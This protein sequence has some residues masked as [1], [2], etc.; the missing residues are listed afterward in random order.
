MRGVIR[1]AL[2]MTVVLCA[3]GMLAQENLAGSTQTMAV[4]EAT[5]VAT[6][7]AA[8][9]WVPASSVV[10]A[11]DAGLRAHTNI[12]LFSLD[13]NKPAG[14][15]YP[16][17]FTT[18]T[19]DAMMEAETPASLGCLYV[20]SPSYS[21]CAPDPDPLTGGPSA[22]GYGAIAIVDAFDNPNAATDLTQFDNYWGL[23][24]PANFHKIL[25]T[26]ASI[27]CG[28]PAANANWSLESSLDI[29]WAHVFAPK[30]QIVLVE[31]SDNSYTCL[32]Y[33]EQV[34]FTYVAAHYSGGHVSNSWG[35]SEFSGQ[36]SYDPMFAGYTYSYTKQI[37]GFASTGDN[38][39]GV[40]YPSTNPW[41]V[42]VGGTSVVRDSATSAF[43]AEAC[44]GGAGGGTSSV[45]TYATTWNNGAQ[46][47]PWANYQ[48]PIFGKAARAV[49]D[50]S[51]DA[52]PS[53]GVWVLSQYGAGGWVVVGGTS[54]SSPAVAGIINRTR[55][56]LGGVF[57]Y[58]IANNNGYFTTEENNF[59]YSQMAA[60]NTY[61]RNFYDVTTGSN[62]CTMGAVAYW[63]YCTGVGSPRGM[64]GK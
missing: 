56:M 58:P 48:Y 60:H 15:P 25:A 47:G 50:I 20:G 34:A 52:D 8:H 46:M 40:S 36:F 38:G 1:F 49:P 27:G 23:Q 9:V 51:F 16:K 24:A 55:N 45:E 29:E 22:N 7:Q 19:G 21:G 35:G 31:A 42:A 6:P 54:L 41:V 62:G 26:N 61:V 30:A 39:C 14:L 59:I 3:L 11:A 33:A 2:L 13:G 64:L 4:P 12:V 63:D 28:T 17:A 10:R 43:S 57:L 44:W 5:S 32:M 37:T 53:S 18:P